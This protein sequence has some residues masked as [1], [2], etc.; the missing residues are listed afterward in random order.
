MIGTMSRQGRTARYRYRGLAA[1]LSAIAL[2][3]TPGLPALGAGQEPAALVEQIDAP[4]LGLEFMDFVE[5]GTEIVLAPGERLT[6]S[7]LQSCILEEIEGARVIVGESQSEVSGAGTV[8][9]SEVDCDGGG[10]V[11][12]KRQNQKIAGLVMRG[13]NEPAVLVYSTEPLFVFR[14]PVRHLEVTLEIPGYY[15][16]YN[17]TVT[18]NHVDLADERL[19]LRPGAI[20][21]AKADGEKR[22]FKIDDD[23]TA[24]DRPAIGRLVGF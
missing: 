10:I 8:V 12:T 11:P 5:A 17:F 14:E 7:Y 6:L 2:C 22:L 1:L 20:Y 15:E 9:R 19:Q 13:E 16:V 4:S 3:L 21:S 18:G 23:A 24:T